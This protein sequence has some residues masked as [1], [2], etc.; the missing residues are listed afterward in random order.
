MIINTN[1]LISYQAERVLGVRTRP[2]KPLIF[3]TSGYSSTATHSATCIS[4]TGLQ[5]CHVLDQ[6]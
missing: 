6:V 4:V 1:N 5:L 2:R 3:K